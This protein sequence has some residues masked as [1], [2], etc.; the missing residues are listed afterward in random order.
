MHAFHLGCITTWPLRSCPICGPSSTTSHDIISSSSVYLELEPLYK[1]DKNNIVKSSSVLRTGKW[2]EEEE[3]YINGL[4]EA[5]LETSIYCANGTSVRLVLA[6][7]LHCSPMRLSKKFQKKALGKHTFRLPTSRLITLDINA[8]TSSIS[9]LYRLKK[10][11]RSSLLPEEMEGVREASMSFWYTQFLNFSKYM[12]QPVVGFDFQKKKKRSRSDNETSSVSNVNLPW[13]RNST[14]YTRQKISRVEKVDMFVGDI[15]SDVARRGSWMSTS[16]SMSDIST[17]CSSTTSASCSEV[18]ENENFNASS[19]APS[20]HPLITF[21]SL[22]GEKRQ[23]LDVD[24]VGI[25][26][27]NTMY[28]TEFSGPYTDIYYKNNFLLS[29]PDDVQDDFNHI[30]DKEGLGSSHATINSH[31]DWLNS[32]SSVS[33][34]ST[35]T[36]SPSTTS[37]IENTTTT[38]PPIGLFSDKELL[39]DLLPF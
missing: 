36:T 4:I 23:Q 25:T 15:K 8:S 21:T 3:V 16:T 2:R 17:L 13:I 22:F 18:D 35:T 26:T 19:F 39:D 20:T 29:P 37:A 31:D 32:C 1:K 24:V 38:F 9:K 5:F 10:E 33:R 6:S 11:F 34:A 28:D 12:G 27:S 30:L 7:E 14:N